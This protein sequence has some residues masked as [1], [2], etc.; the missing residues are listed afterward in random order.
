MKSYHIH[1]LKGSRLLR[2]SRI[3]WIMPAE[4]LLLIALH[5]S[6]NACL[7]LDRN[8]WEL[9]ATSY[10]GEYTSEVTHWEHTAIDHYHLNVSHEI[11]WTTWCSLPH[12]IWWPRIMSED[13]PYT[14]NS[15]S[16]IQQ[17]WRVPDNVYISTFISTAQVWSPYM[18]TGGRGRTTQKVLCEAS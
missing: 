1:V 2:F 17:Q 3:P 10:H 15:F 12:L 7:V 16:P 13:R 6:W 5:F 8:N 4:K 11:L 9:N 18:T 14:R